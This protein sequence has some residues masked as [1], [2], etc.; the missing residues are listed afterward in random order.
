[1]S[2]PSDLNRLTPR[3]SYL[4]LAI[5]VAFIVVLGFWQSYFGHLLGGTANRPWIIHVHAAIFV[6]WLGLLIAQVTAIVRG[7]VS[8][9]NGSVSQ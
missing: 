9:S 3:R 8:S 5:G 2:F 4:A 6:G 7:R 1:M